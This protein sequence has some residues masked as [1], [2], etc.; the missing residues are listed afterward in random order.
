MYEGGSEMGNMIANLTGDK[1]STQIT[2]PGNQI[3]V[4]FHTNGNIVGKGFLGNILESMYLV[5]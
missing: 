2:I 1:S 4:V 5:L 3:F